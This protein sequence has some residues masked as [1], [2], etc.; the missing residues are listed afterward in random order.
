MRDA[1]HVTMVSVVSEENMSD[2]VRLALLIGGFTLIGISITAGA[3]L[4]SQW[5]NGHF[6]VKCKM[7]ELW[8]ARKIDSYQRVLNLTSD[9]AIDPNNS[10]KYV[11]FV[12][13][14][15]AASIVASSKV[16]DL[17]T[18]RHDN[19]L[20]VNAKRLRSLE[21]KEELETFRR[22]KWSAAV[23]SIADAM[24]EDVEEVA[25]PIPTKAR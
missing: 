18:E 3:A 22:A 23:D 25:A 1:S 13:S 19:S 14:L 17:L 2:A 5:I 24:R 21:T 4:I 16:N 8:L 9:F 20:S 12:A 11:P 6:S 7:T 10:K 15:A